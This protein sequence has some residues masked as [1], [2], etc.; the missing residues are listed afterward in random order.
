M[1]I[2]M[3]HI[4]QQDGSISHQIGTTTQDRLET[5]VKEHMR[6]RRKPQIFERI[7]GARR[8]EQ[9]ILCH[10]GNLR[11]ETYFKQ[12]SEALIASQICTHCPPHA[13]PPP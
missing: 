10:H 9:M 3:L 8:V 6:D 1:I 7:N 12:M 11:L 13:E 5:R 2:Y 4:E